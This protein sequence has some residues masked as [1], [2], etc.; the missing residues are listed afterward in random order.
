MGHGKGRRDILSIPDQIPMSPAR[1][2]HFLRR[3]WRLLLVFC[4]R[5][6]QIPQNRLQLEQAHAYKL[7]VRLVSCWRPRYQQLRELQLQLRLTT[8]FLFKEIARPTFC[9]HWYDGCLRSPVRGVRA[10]EPVSQT[11]SL[12]KRYKKQLQKTLLSMRS[13]L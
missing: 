3:D 8:D 4:E 2:I 1:K 7:Q 11:P 12:R 5:Y 6:E 10:H 9:R 13:N